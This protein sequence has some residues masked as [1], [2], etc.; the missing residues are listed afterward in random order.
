M[1]QNS[2]KWLIFYASFVASINDV[3]PRRGHSLDHK[4]FQKRQM[5]PTSNFIFLTFT[6]IKEGQWVSKLKKVAVVTKSINGQGVI[7]EWYYNLAMS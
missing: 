4:I 3:P 2:E 6:I 1:I 7:S 5:T